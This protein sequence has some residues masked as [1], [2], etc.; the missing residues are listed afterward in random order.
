M[1]YEFFRGR[2]NQAYMLNVNK[3]FLKFLTLGVN[4]SVRNQSYNQLGANILLKLGPVVWFM[5]SDNV[6]SFLQPEGAR[7]TN[8]RMGMTLSLK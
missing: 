6:I 7:Y 1:H 5:G 3:D 4:Y 2:I 8:V